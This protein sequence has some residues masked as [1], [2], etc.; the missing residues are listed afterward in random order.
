[1]LEGLI[2]VVEGSKT[3]T[4]TNIILAV[5]IIFHLICEFGHY[6]HEFISRRKDTRKLSDNNG[7]LQN[8]ISRV[9]KIEETISNKKCPLKKEE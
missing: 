1:M 9:E 5:C 4:V 3:L 6:I 2:D 8:L 7:L